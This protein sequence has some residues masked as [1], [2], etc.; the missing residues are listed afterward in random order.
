MAYTTIKKPGDYF[1]TKL[2]TG[3]NGTHAITGVGFQ[4]DFIW[5]KP[6]NLA[7]HHR[8]MNSVSSADTFLKSNS[9]GAE[10]NTGV[11]FSSFDSDGF[12]LGGN[13][14]GWNSSSYNYTSWNWKANG[15]GSA[16]TDGSI[17]STV[18]V[19]ATSGFSIVKYT[20]T[21]ANATVGHGLGV[22]PKMII[23]K[24]TEATENW[25][26]YHQSLENTSALKLNQTNAKGT[27][28]AYWN[29][30][31]PTSSTFSLGASSEANTNADVNIAYCFRDVVGYSKFGSYVG[32]GNANGAFVYTGF[33]PA[34]VIIK[35]TSGTANWIMWDNKRNPSNVTNLLLKPNLNDAE[36]TSTGNALDFTS[37]GFKCRG[38][39]SGSNASGGNYIYL[40]FAEQPLI[41]D[42]PATAR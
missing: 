7:D 17:S 11:N 18:S 20:G 1:N 5:L 13:N 19:S 42:N 28:S 29:N 34:F 16:N 14:G 31:S 27:T 38:T 22:A 3:N 24:N 4:P 21:G 26:V 9:N 41:G 23:V 33:K 15:T 36:N 39:D 12:T 32:N 6:R 30:T 2:Y 8:L 40:A 35:Y 10:D 25:L 37:N